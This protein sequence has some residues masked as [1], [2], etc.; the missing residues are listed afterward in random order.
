MCPKRNLTIVV[1]NKCDTTPVKFPMW[2]KYKN[3]TEVVF[4]GLLTES[5]YDFPLSRSGKTT[6]VLFLYLGHM[7]N[8]TGV[9]P[10]LLCTTK[11]RFLLEYINPERRKADQGQAF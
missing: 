7:G 8:F 10:C 3:E 11:V 1:R 5:C 6:I 2:S 4:S 9:A